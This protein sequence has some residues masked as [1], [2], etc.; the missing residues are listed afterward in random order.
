MFFQI[1][2]AWV[3][4]IEHRLGLMRVGRRIR[5][6]GMGQLQVISGRL[7]LRVNYG[8][9][10]SP[11]SI[12]EEQGISLPVSPMSSAIWRMRLPLR[13][14]LDALCEEVRYQSYALIRIEPTTT[15]LYVRLERRL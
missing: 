4:S 10:V 2:L 1:H 5:G 9:R 11:D 7:G 13:T 3:T 6:R 8:T 14:R 12:F 15:I